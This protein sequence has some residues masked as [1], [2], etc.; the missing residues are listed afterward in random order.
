VVS[1]YPPGVTG[2]EYQISGAE[3]EWEEERECP[4]CGWEG[5]MVHESHRQIGVWAWCANPELT[6]P[7][8][9][10]LMPCPLAKEGFEVIAPGEGEE[11]ALFHA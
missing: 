6:E 1:N 5:P 4:H 7:T 10:G 11:D 8:A 9:S 3:R 2:N